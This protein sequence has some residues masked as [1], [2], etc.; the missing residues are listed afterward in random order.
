MNSNEKRYIF[1][2]EDSKEIRDLI[3]ILYEGEGY[4]VEF[5]SDG[6]EALEMLRAGAEL[7]ALILLDLMMP[8]MDG[9]QFRAE[10][11]KDPRLSSIPILVMSA[12]AAA[13]IKAMKLGAKGYLRKPVSVDTLVEVA[14]KY[15]S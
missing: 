8:V 10:Q 6:K 11:E 12:D 3:K 9:F 5:A 14:E 13:D 4:R 15:C 1:V 2:V 7:P